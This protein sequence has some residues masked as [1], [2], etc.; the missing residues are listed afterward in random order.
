MTGLTNPKPV[1]TNGLAEDSVREMSLLFDTADCSHLLELY[2]NVV[3]LLTRFR[4]LN[5]LF[6]Y[7]A[8]T[9]LSQS[10]LSHL[11]TPGSLT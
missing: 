9:S 6:G 2:A 3:D 8:S 4:P 11:C 10:S 5:S 7:N 1:A